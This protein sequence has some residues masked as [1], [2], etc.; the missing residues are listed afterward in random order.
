VDCV[1]ARFDADTSDSC[2]LS[3]VFNASH[4]FSVRDSEAQGANTLECELPG[5]SLFDYGGLLDVRWLHT[6]FLHNITWCGPLLTRFS[7]GV[8]RGGGSH[9]FLPGKTH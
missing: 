9:N 6:Q 5:C 4:Y 3:S 8:G 7:F 2:L 1:I